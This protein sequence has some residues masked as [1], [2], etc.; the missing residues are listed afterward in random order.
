MTTKPRGVEARIR[1]MLDNPPGTA[2]MCA[3]TCWQA[4][5]GDYGMPPAWGAP[6]ANAVYDK[7]LAS[8][9]YSRTF[10]A[11]RGALIVW[12]Y[13]KHGHTALSAGGTQIYTTDP[14]G[15]PG[16]T[17]VEPIGYPHKWGANTR[18]RLWTSSYAG[19]PFPVGTETDKDDPVAI[20]KKDAHLI[21]DIVWQRKTFQN[22]AGTD[23][24]WAPRGYIK[25]MW[26]YLRDAVTLLSR[27]DARLERIEAVATNGQA[28]DLD[29]YEAP[30]LG[31]SGR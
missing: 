11:P 4:L 8:G 16:G 23:E 18:D 15:R 13:G 27:I 28:L 21:A 29:G 9:K 2:G 26:S 24:S 19:V 3:R 10:P 12:R 17:G 31:D 6:D 14:T 22:P 7:V 25:G 5:G 1:W 20:T 30:E